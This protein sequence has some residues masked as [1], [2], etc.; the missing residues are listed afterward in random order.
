MS[1]VVNAPGH[2]LGIIQQGPRQLVIGAVL[3]AGIAVSG[4]TV[5]WSAHDR[6]AVA[7]NRGALSVGAVHPESGT[8][9]YRRTRPAQASGAT[10]R[11]RQRHHPNAAPTV[12]SS[13]E[14]AIKDCQ[15]HRLE[16]C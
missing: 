6:A 13:L 1:A 8:I 9:V 16:R 7:V 5:G 2:R 4:F 10:A 3:A 15:I 12:W 14:Q 11:D